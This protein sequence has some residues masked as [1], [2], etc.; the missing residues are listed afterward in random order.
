VTDGF[1]IG[2][3][4]GWRVRPGVAGCRAFYGLGGPRLALV[5]GLGPRLRWSRR[6]ERPM[7][8]LSYQPE[9]PDCPQPEPDRSLEPLLDG[10]RWPN[11]T[12]LGKELRVLLPALDHIRGPVTRL[13][14]GVGNWTARPHQIVTDGR[15]VSIGYAAGQSSTMIKIFCADGGTFTM[16]V[17]PLDPA[18][19]APDPPEAGWDE[20]VWEA[21]GGGLG[22]PRNLAVR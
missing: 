8:S 9:S 15:T 11:S 22:M 14:L 6:R 19:V 18:P 3:G 10:N 2:A 7:A 1:V 21:E 12:D 5:I 4:L 20:D 17:A 13:L 16:R